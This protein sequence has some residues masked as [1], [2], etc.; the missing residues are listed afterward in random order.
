M[1][2]TRFEVIFENPL[3]F[4]VFVEAEDREEAETIAVEN[5]FPSSEIP[6]PPGFELNDGWFV[7]G[8]VRVRDDD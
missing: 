2:I 1:W 6:L 3:Y 5:H 7:E 4:S 8:S